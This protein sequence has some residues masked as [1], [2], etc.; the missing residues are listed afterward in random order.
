MREEESGSELIV[1]LLVVD[2]RD[3]TGVFCDVQMEEERE[4]EG[5]RLDVAVSQEDV[6]VQK[7]LAGR[8]GRG[9]PRSFVGF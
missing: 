7:F 9:E 4:R 8:L 3:L 2:W 6:R 1:S 5:G